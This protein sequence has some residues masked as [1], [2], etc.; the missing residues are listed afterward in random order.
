MQAKRNG[1][2]MP[3]YHWIVFILLILVCCIEIV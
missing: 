2:G 3:R 1:G